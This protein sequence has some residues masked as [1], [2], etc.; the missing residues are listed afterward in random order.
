M[1]FLFM[2]FLP[3]FVHA[4]DVRENFKEDTIYTKTVRVPYNGLIDTLTGKPL[5]IWY[6]N[7]KAKHGYI[8]KLANGNYVINGKVIKGDYLKL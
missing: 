6:R 8:I 4:Q 5:K 3:V 1:K 2:L 7:V